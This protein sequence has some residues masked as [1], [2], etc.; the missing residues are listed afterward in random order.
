M[1]IVIPCYNEGS[2]LNI[3]AYVKYLGVSANTHLVFSND[4][5]TDDT[6]RLL[7]EIRST[8][9]GQVSV[10]NASRNQG[11]AEAVR[12]AMELSV[13]KFPEAEKFAYLDADL[14]VTLEECT[15]ISAG[16]APDV[17][18][19]F[20]SR[21][22]KIDSN[23]QRS[24]FRHYTGRILATL[25]SGMLKLPV[26]DTQ[27]GCKVFAESVARKLFADRFTSR[28]LF[29]VEIFLRLKKEFS[30]SEIVRRSREVPLRSWIDSGESKVRLQYFFRLWIDMYKIK[31]RYR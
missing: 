19:A 7:E 25:T 5:S 1:I 13:Q 20:G 8:F 21:I 9:P 30:A 26:Y 31:M 2:R 16:M 17:I 10:H 27:C 11:K 3:Q 22:M 28:W 23:I 14:A 6:I 29:D 24:T 15:L 18:F 12:S 4:G